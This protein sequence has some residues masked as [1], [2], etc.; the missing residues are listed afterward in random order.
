MRSFLLILYNESCSKNRIPYL[1]QKN[2]LPKYILCTGLYEWDTIFI[3]VVNLR[4]S[5]VT[6]QTKCYQID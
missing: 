3:L 6:I 4:I 2:W 5:F 1:V